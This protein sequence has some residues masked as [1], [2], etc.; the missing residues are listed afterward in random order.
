MYVL[1]SNGKT[2]IAAG[3]YSNSEL[4][5]EL[6]KYEGGGGVEDRAG[7]RVRRVL[8]RESMALR[9]L[10]SRAAPGGD[11]QWR[12]C[13]SGRRGACGPSEDEEEEA[14]VEEQ[15]DQGRADRDLVS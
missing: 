10:G 12:A 5:F 15:D 6:K 4:P 2:Y 14:K 13:R 8:A 1:L 3:C 11:R 7:R 9:Q